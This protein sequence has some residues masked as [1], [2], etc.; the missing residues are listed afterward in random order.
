MAYRPDPADRREPYPPQ[1]GPQYGAGPHGYR[2]GTGLA[3][4]AVVVG[5]LA[6]IALVFTFGGLFFI[7]LPLGIAAMIM[8][9]V[10]RRRA[11]T[12]AADPRGRGRARGG[13]WTG[14][15]ATILSLL[16]ALLIAIG[17]AL[18]S[19]LDLEGLPD[20]IQNLIPDRL[21]EDVQ[22]DTPEVQNP[23]RGD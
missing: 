9:S 19:N 18:L 4:A 14:L 3:T 12:G 8:G 16:V 1:H 7:A 23:P 17:V 21:Q 15:I 5:I 2:H 13:F 22:V 6:L 10:A 11:E 20:D